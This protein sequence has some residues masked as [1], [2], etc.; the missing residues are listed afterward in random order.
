M[1]AFI[2]LNLP[3][4]LYLRDGT[5]KLVVPDINTLDPISVILSKFRREKEKIDYVSF[6]RA[7]QAERGELWNDK[8]GTFR[9]TSV[10]IIFPSSVVQPLSEPEASYYEQLPSIIDAAVKIV[11]RLITVYRYVT[12]DTYIPIVQPDDINNV[13]TVGTCSLSPDGSIQGQ[14]RQSGVDYKLINTIPDYDEATH[15]EIGNWFSTGELIPLYEEFMMSARSLLQDSN[16]RASVIEAQTAFEAFVSDR[17]RQYYLGQGLSTADVEKKMK[18]G[19]AS[20]STTHLTKAVG[21][22]FDI[23]KANY[24]RWHKDTYLMRNRVVHDGYSP[25][26]QEAIA[27]VLGVEYALEYL[28]GRPKEKFWSKAKPVTVVNEFFVPDS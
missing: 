11:N 17:V 4:C 22:K 16:W 12:R 27:A 19:F 8:Y 24:D 23:G 28:V 2:K 21:K 5:Y 3:F 25:L 15:K 13:F 14:G 20:L 26:P 10:V 1:N 7:E 18:C 9:R 6:W